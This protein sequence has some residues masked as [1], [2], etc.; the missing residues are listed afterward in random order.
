MITAEDL[1][2]AD[3]ISKTG[4]NLD[5]RPGCRTERFSASYRAIVSYI[6][7]HSVASNLKIPKLIRNGAVKICSPS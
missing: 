3:E 4:P 1:T 2:E 7:H 6:S 5:H